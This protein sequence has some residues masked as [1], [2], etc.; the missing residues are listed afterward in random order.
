MSNTVHLRKFSSEEL[1]L[2]ESETRTV[3]KFFWPEEPTATRIEESLII[4][5]SVQEFAQSVL[6]EAVD[7]SYQV[8]SVEAIFRAAANP[9]RGALKVIKN[10]GKRA[11]KHW[12]KNARASDLQNVR[13]Y[14]FIRQH[15]SRTFR[16]RLEEHLDGIARLDREKPLVA[17]LSYPKRPEMPKVWG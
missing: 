1:I 12:F 6:V 11:S 13:I 7:A 5:D 9:G 2:S 8:G 4:D 15:I 10:F 16:V 3:L 17:L 14:E